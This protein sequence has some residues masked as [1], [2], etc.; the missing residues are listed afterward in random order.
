MRDW[1][2]IN[3]PKPLRETQ[4]LHF[5]KLKRNIP[6]YNYTTLLVPNKKLYNHADGRKDPANK[7]PNIKPHSKHSLQ[8][9]ILIYKAPH[10]PVSKVQI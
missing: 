1:D 2:K 3:F 5:S 4:L 6:L 8:S 9:F 10:P 7:A